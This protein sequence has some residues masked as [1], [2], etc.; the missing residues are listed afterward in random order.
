MMENESPQP[1]DGAGSASSLAGRAASRA[2]TLQ[3]LSRLKSR[4]VV[5]TLLGFGALSVLVAGHRVGTTT[6]TT[7]TPPAAATPAPSTDDGGGFYNQG[8]GQ[9]DNGG[10]GGFFNGGG[11]GGQGGYGFGNGGYAQPPVAGSG[12]S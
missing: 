7:T 1:A 3:R 11:S 9:D 10:N 6:A 12:A 4:I 8:N 5:T 2:A